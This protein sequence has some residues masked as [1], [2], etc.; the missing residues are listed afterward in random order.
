MTLRAMERVCDH[1]LEAWYT[2]Q[3]EVGPKDAK[4]ANL[5]LMNKVMQV[6]EDEFDFEFPD[7]A[8][9][10]KE[11]IDPNYYAEVEGAF[12]A[13]ENCAASLTDLKVRTR[14]LIFEA[15]YSWRTNTY[16]IVNISLRPCVWETGLI[17]QLTDYA[18]KGLSKVGAERDVGLRFVIN[19]YSRAIVEMTMEEN[20]AL[21][22][23]DAS[24]FKKEANFVMARDVFPT[25]V[26]FYANS[27]SEKNKRGWSPEEIKN[28]ERINALKAR[29]EALGILS[30]TFANAGVAK[31]QK[32]N[33]VKRA[34]RDS[35]SAVSE[36]L[37][38][39]Q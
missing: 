27:V 29:F 23:P 36:P 2:P 25:W 22:K 7:S 20:R 13:L 38:G 35:N 21:F 30:R 6:V 31:K 15:A 18:V 24:M 8:D 19:G 32:A 14:V 26:T 34:T 33:T 5:E 10:F 12:R 4:K 17:R 1:M 28:M 9:G 3:V 11:G 16:D 37:V 39:G